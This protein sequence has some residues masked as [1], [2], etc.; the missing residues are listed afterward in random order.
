[1]LSQEVTEHLIK[2]SEKVARVEQ[3]YSNAKLELKLL[4]AQYILK[5]DWEEVLGK[6]KPTQKEKD[7]FIIL[8]TEEKRRE[9]DEL[10]IKVDYCRRIQ[11]IN[12]VANV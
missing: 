12:M 10:K 5:N 2:C 11:E 6:K 1:M 3:K 8:S 4:E 9:V 7:A